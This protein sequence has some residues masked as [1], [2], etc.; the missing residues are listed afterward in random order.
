MCYEG[1]IDLE[2]VKDLKDKAAL[3]VQIMEFGQIPKQIF[4][5]PHP[6]RNSTH[7]PKLIT[8]KHPDNT[9]VNENISLESK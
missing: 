7:I 8:Q 6:S 5:E 1:A 9:I 3:E 4:T 2:N